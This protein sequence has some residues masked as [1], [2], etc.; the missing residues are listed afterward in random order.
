MIEAIRMLGVC[1]FER[2]GYFVKGIV[3]STLPASS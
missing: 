3:R 1:E 2:Y